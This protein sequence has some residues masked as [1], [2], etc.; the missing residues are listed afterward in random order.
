[1]Y[2]ELDRCFVE[3]E[4]YF[5]F[6]QVTVNRYSVFSGMSLTRKSLLVFLYSKSSSKDS[7]EQGL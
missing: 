5:I 1:M 4:K 7:T 3:L 2:F 6:F